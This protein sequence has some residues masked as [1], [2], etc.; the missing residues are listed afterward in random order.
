MKRRPSIFLAASLA[1]I[2]LHAGGL[3]AQNAPVIRLTF[4][5]AVRLALQANPELQ[6]ANLDVALRQQD[7][8]I[9]RSRLLPQAAMRVS[10]G[11]EQINLGSTFGANL[12]IF[13]HHIGP[14]QVFQAGPEFSTPVFHLTLW[15]KL[16]SSR[17]LLNGSR[18]D[19]R[20]SWRE[21]LWRFQA[22]FPSHEQLAGFRLLK[23]LS[24]DFL[25]AGT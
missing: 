16:P 19:S 12:L 4:Q 14:F 15:R 10:D 18:A 11:A 2:S 20:M 9:S 7:A 1:M 23:A 22:T 17:T 25:G 8:R 13:P 21:P 3:V 5:E 6:N 24:C